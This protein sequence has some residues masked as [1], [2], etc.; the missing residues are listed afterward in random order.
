IPPTITSFT[1]TSGITG[2]SVTIT[3]TYLSGATVKFGNLIASSSTVQSPTQMRARVP[4][5]A[6]PGKISVITAAGTATSTQSFSPTLSITGYSPT[7]GP[8][9]TVVDL[10]GI[11]FTAGST[12]KFNGTA[13][14]SVSYVSPGEVKATVP[15]AAMSGPIALTTPAGTVQAA[16]KYTLTTTALASHALRTS[17]L[18]IITPLAA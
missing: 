13:S 1:P 11:G 14:S 9:G 18:A 4:N 6:I 7:S 3:G 8:V 10:K 2:S 16:R 17:T 12:V 15:A 5:G